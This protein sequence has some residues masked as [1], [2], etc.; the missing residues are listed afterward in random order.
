MLESLPDTQISL[1]LE[2]CR[3]VTCMRQWKPRLVAAGVQE[4]VFEDAQDMIIDQLNSLGTQ[5]ALT[6]PVLEGNMRDAG[7]SPMVVMYLRLLTSA[8]LG[9]RQDFFAPFIMV[10]RALDQGGSQDRVGHESSRGIVTEELA[11]E[12]TKRCTY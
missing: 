12:R 4:L 7:V 3:V 6:L 1:M 2:C 10:S 8:E 9:R 11:A 5:D